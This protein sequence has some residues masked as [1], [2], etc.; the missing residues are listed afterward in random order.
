MSDS[1][2]Q[3]QKLVSCQT[4]VVKFKNWFHIKHR[5]SNF[6]KQFLVNT[7]KDHFPYTFIK[8]N[9]KYKVWLEIS[10][11]DIRPDTIKLVL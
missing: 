11:K 2:S 4:Q 9:Q 3:I 6:K 10:I 1:G 8:N 7:F 5:H